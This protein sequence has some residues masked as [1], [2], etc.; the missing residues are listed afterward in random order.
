MTKEVC[1]HDA[2]KCIVIYDITCALYKENHAADDKNCS[3]YIKNKNLNQLMACQ[4][5]PVTPEI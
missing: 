1:R 5:T 2:E 4:N 3:V